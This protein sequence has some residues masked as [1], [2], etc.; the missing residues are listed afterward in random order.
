MAAQPPQRPVAKEEKFTAAQKERIINRVDNQE[1]GVAQHFDL[2]IKEESLKRNVRRWKQNLA[3][4]GHLTNLQRGAH[5]G[6][7]F[8][9]SET[10]SNLIEQAKRLFPDMMAHE[11]ILWLK[12]NGCRCALFFSPS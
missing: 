2:G 9:L 11:M 6:V 12:A 1:I 3:D 10:E 7:K 4:R 5:K 8:V